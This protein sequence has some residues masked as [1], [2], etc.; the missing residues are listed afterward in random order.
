MCI[1][2]GS[3]LGTA[4]SREKIKVGMS[5]LAPRPLG[6]VREMLASFVILLY[7]FNEMNIILV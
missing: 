1:H 7:I 4:S 5:A 6:L 3:Q 2:A